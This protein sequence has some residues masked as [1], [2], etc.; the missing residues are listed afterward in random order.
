MAGWLDCHC[1]FDRIWE[2]PTGCGQD[3]GGHHPGGLFAMDR[4]T[5]VEHCVDPALEVF[6]PAAPSQACFAFPPLAKTFSAL[7]GA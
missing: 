7:E 1:N 6:L 3:L 5:A 2:D 4:P